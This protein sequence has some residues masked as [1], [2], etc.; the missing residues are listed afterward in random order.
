MVRIFKYISFNQSGEMFKIIDIA[1]LLHLLELNS[2][3]FRINNSLPCRP[4]NPGPPGMKQIAYQCAT[5]LRSK[6][7]VKG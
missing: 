7:E 6:G 5:V 2:F 3:L 4:L 1:Y